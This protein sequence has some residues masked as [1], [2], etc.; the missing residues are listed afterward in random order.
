MANMKRWIVTYTKHTKQ[1]RKV[2]QDGFLELDISTNKIILYDDCERLLECR[3]AK[4]DEVVSSGET[5]TFNAYL[6]DVGDPEG[7]HKPL[8]DLNSQGSDKKITEKPGLLKRQKFRNHSVSFGID[9]KNDVEKNKA[10]PTLSPS[11]KIIREFKKSELHKYKA[12]QSSPDTTKPS[13]AEWQ[14]LYTTQVTQKA[15]KYHDGF[16]RL[17]ACGSLGRQVMLF[18]ASKKL[19]NS[20]FLKKDEVI[21]SGESIAF[22]AHLVELGEPDG[23]LKPFMDSNVQRDNCNVAKETGTMHRQEN[24]V[25]LSK[26][27]EKEFEKSKLDKHG[28]PESSPDKAKLTLREWQ[29]L[30]TTQLTQKAKK[31]HDG[32]LRLAICGS[33]GRQVLLYDAS[34]KLLGSRF[35]KKYEVIKSGESIELDGHLIEI[36]E[37]EGNREPLMDLNIQVN[38]G[39]IIQKSGLM[40]GQQVCRTD[41]KSVVKEWHALYTSQIVR[42]SKKYHSGILKVSF[43][44]SFQMQ[45][46]L[47][48][49]D[50]TILSRKFLSLSEDVRTGTLLE[51]PKYLVEVGEPCVSP[52]GAPQNNACLEKD[53]VSKF[54]VSSVDEIKL[55]RRVPPNK[56]IRDAHQILSNLQKPMAQESN[57]ADYMDNSTMEMGSSIK[58]PQVADTVLLDFPEDIQPPRASLQHHESSENVGIWESSENIDIGNSPDLISCE[59]ISSRNGSELSKDVDLDNSHQPCLDKVEAGPQRCDGAFPFGKS[60]STPCASY[61]PVDDVKKTS[62]EHTCT[63][64]I[65]EPPSFDLGF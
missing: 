62:K 8:S 6:V 57:V 20:R 32:F 16:L 3:I 45:V 31:Y 4:K 12:P 33:L 61:D 54:S 22:D 18:D 53:A 63:R 1:K 48:N 28:A 26:H 19:L 37:L 51:L 7:D 40:H 38:D 9:R 59:A 41:K 36:G 15:K 29:V 35:L 5:L 43:C 60:I 64:E 11:H 13:I 39:N 46:T 21:R 49:E 55:S 44:G 30:Y 27:V 47:L 34:R 24:Y 58:E 65:E 56:P 52:E 2:Y 10:R 25:D 23:E 50:K 14:V 17:S 42:R